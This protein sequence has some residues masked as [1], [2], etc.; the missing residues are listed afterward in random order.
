MEAEREG[1]AVVQAGREKV[2]QILKM[3]ALRGVEDVMVSERGD[4]G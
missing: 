4:D 1:G 2:D 3:K